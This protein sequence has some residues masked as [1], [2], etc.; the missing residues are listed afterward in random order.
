MSDNIQGSEDFQI[1]AD[2]QVT[3]STTDEAPPLTQDTPPPANQM[4]QARA[5]WTKGAQANGVEL[6][7]GV[8][9]YEKM[10]DIMQGITPA[11]GTAE[12]V[13]TEGDIE[14]PPTIEEAIE[15][16]DDPDKLEVADP[17]SKEA[18]IRQKMEIT[19]A[20]DSWGKELSETGTLTDSSREQIK[21][22]MGV[23]DQVIDAYVTGVKAE[24]QRSY[25]EASTIVGSTDKLNAVLNWA[26]TAMSVE[27]RTAANQALAGPNRETYLTGLV[28]QYEKSHPTQTAKANE[29]AGRTP[30]TT[31]SP[32]PAAAAPRPF[33]SEQDMAF[34][35]RDYRYGKDAAYTN[36]VVARLQVTYGKGS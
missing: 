14:I 18:E 23:P 32:A 36:E 2:A 25:N 20:W 16:S 28:A 1:P 29:P 9:S 7:E 22:L 13:T 35:M 26:S 17:E 6:M 15:V 21:S 33:M 12:E 3:A 8:D 11:P 30:G 19:E 4:D 31:A 34:A 10:F 5:M 24:A 27:Q